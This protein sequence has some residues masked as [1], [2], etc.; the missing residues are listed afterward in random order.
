[1][2]IYNYFSN[3]RKLYSIQFPLYFTI[4]HIITSTV[5]LYR[6]DPTLPNLTHV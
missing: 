5:Q 3:P 1:M 4:I 6:F 2:I